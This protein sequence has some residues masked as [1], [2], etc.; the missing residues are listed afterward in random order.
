MG[1]TSYYHYDGLGS[2]QLLTDENGNVTDS[3]CN[4]AFGVPV[5]TG[6]ANPTPNP[7]KYVGQQGYFLDQ[8]TGN[9]Y[10]RA[11]TLSPVMARWLS[12]DPI[13]FG[14]GLGDAGGLYYYRRPYN[15]PGHPGVGGFVSWNPILAEINLYRYC[16]NNSPQKTDPS[17]LL[18][19]KYAMN[20]VGPA[21]CV[22]CA[23]TC[24][25]KGGEPANLGL[26]FLYGL[27]MAA[28]TETIATAVCTEI[29][30]GFLAPAA[31]PAAVA[32]RL[33]AGLRS[34]YGPAVSCTCT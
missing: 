7:F 13:G 26:A 16:T 31:E 28:A 30:W 8:D 6:T 10:V 21:G 25:C 9:Y 32:A 27:G 15:R 4:T 2:T 23:G 22:F 17:G 20:V 33:Q 12:Q 3:Y 24:E 5:D 14:G 19:V 34:V 1:Q 18:E 29:A 11:R